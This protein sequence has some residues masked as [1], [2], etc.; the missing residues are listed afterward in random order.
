MESWVNTPKRLTSAAVVVGLSSGLV[1]CGGSP[2]G[3]DKDT[4]GP[5][6]SSKTPTPTP[7]PTPDPRPRVEGKW[8]IVFTPQD[9]EK[10]PDRVTWS[11]A[12]RCPAG[13]CSARVL[14]SSGKRFRFQFDSTIGDY[15]VKGRFVNDCTNQATGETMVK[16]AYRGRFTETFSV[17]KKVKADDG[18]YA[19]NMTGESRIRLRLSPSAA[20]TC[21]PADLSIEDIRAIRVDPPQGKPGSVIADEEATPTGD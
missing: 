4:A 3:S 6:S 19:T 11:L 18:E 7:T 13:P 14:S 2:A 8:R 17:T 15:T 1:A 20:G 10:D 9:P 21:D 16:D 12:P 5:S